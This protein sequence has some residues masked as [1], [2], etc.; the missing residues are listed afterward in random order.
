MK[1]PIRY[2]P[3]AGDQHFTAIGTADTLTGI[4]GVITD[5][6]ITITKYCP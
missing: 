1:N 5:G 6:I 4:L 3:T 2:G